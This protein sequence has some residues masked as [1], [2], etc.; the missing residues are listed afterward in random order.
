MRGRVQ[1]WAALLV[2]AATVSGGLR[3]PLPRMSLPG[4]GRS[5]PQR[6][7]PDDWTARCWPLWN[8]MAA[9]RPS[10]RSVRRPVTRR[11]RPAVIAR[12]KASALEPL[13]D[14]GGIV[15]DYAW[16]YATFIRVTS[17]EQLL[18]VLHEPATS[19]VRVNR[20]VRPA[21]V[22]ANRLIRQPQARAAG[23]RGAGTAVAVLDTGVNYRGQ[24]FGSCTAPG[25]PAGC[26]VVAARDFA[27]QD[28]A[29]DASGHGTG[30]RQGGGLGCA[31]GEAAGA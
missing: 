8:V 3:P 29:L 31:G 21:D 25:R 13:R 6:L 19:G 12:R 18:S 1:R 2:L 16:L 4:R 11:T 22:E 15:R 30:G 5:S 7:P 24:A 10:S 23:Y 26:R 9:S 14:V 28:D 17:A 27:P 20:A